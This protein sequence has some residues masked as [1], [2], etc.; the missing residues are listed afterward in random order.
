MY[1]GVE[2]PIPGGLPDLFVDPADFRAQMDALAHAGAHARDDGAGR[3]GL[4][5]RD[6]AAAQA[7]GAHL[8]RRLPGPGRQRA[9]GDAPHGWP[10]RALH[11]HRELPARDRAHGQGRPHAA[12]RRLGARRP[13]LQPPRPA[14][15]GARR[16]PPR[17]GRVQDLAR[18]P[19][20]RP[21]ELLRLSRG[22]VRPVHRAG[23]ASRP[24]STPRSRWCRAWRSATIPG[25]EPDPSQPRA[26]PRPRSSPSCARWDGAERPPRPRR[27]GARPR[28]AAAAA[29]DAAP[30]GRAGRSSAGATWASTGRT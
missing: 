20:R 16:A 6:A 21:G 5:A 23:R 19:L 25:V 3:G 8:R 27:R 12:P 13:H 7:R 11:V 22:D 14:D 28:A 30:A 9:A 18:A 10:G 4:D 29:A 1:H 17:G 2:A 24:A 26:S 15:A